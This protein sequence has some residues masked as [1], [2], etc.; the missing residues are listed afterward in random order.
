MKRGKAL[1]FIQEL[2]LKGPGEEQ[3]KEFV[4]YLPENIG[5]L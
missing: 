2:F 1:K 5:I 3:E 4:K